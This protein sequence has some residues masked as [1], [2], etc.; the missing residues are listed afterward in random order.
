MHAIID[1][2]CF[3]IGVSNN[4]DKNLMEK[5]LLSTEKHLHSK[6]GARLLYWLGIGWR[7]YTAW[8][9]KGTADR[10]GVRI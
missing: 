5:T 3:G 9:M 1:V 7:N 8:H 10:I 4:R 6:T 2:A